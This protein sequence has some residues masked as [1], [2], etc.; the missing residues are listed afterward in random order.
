MLPILTVPAE[1]GVTAAV[2]LE[3]LRIV[4]GDV[5]V[6]R[7]NAADILGDGTASYDFD[8][9][10]LTLANANIT[11]VQP[12]YTNDDLNLQLP[13]GTTSRLTLAEGGTAVISA[14]NSDIIAVEAPDAAGR[15]KL[16]LAGNGEDESWG[17]RSTGYYLFISGIALEIGGVTH[18]LEAAWNIS[19]LSGSRVTCTA[20]AGRAVSAREIQFYRDMEFIIS[21]S[22]T[23][24]AADPM[25]LY[26][27]NILDD[28]WDEAC[29]PYVETQLGEKDLLLKDSIVKQDGKSLLRCGDGVT[30]PTYLRIYTRSGEETT[31]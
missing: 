9:N 19:V 25:L 15:P 26:V 18:A 10:I 27:D 24:P 11:A 31:T 13:A 5:P 4:V 17:V 7:E 21:S 14:V 12:I 30:Y 20:D 16:I 6:T 23:A 22:L 1:H 3:P 8:R 28:G 29:P 2:Y